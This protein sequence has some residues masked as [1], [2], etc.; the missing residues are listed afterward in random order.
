MNGLPL[1][2]TAALRRRD[3]DDRSFAACSPKMLPCS[4]DHAPENDAPLSSERLPAS[5]GLPAPERY[6]APLPCTS[7]Q[8]AASPS[9]RVNGSTLEPIDAETALSGAQTGKVVTKGRNSSTAAALVERARR[10]QMNGRRLRDGWSASMLG[11]RIEVGISIGHPVVAQLFERRFYSTARSL[12]SM[13]ATLRA[14]L[15]DDVVTAAEERVQ[16]VIVAA[17][18]QLDQ[19]GADLAKEIE[20]AGARAAL[21]PAHY[22]EAKVRRESV[23]LSSPLARELL[24]LYPQADACLLYLETLYLNGVSSSAVR[25][26]QIYRVK[27]CLLDL[28]LEIRRIDRKMLQRL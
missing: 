14:L 24:M 15:P 21:L 22:N 3:Y 11:A 17:A 7:C 23:L 19:R 26:E 2:P 16:A 1:F 9:G 5:S 27:R 10:E 6:G 12:H 18:H 20:Q 25:N 4:A 13:S 8:T 28:E